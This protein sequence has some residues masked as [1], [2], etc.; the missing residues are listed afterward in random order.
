MHLLNRCGAPCIIYNTSKS[1]LPNGF[2]WWSTETHFR[3]RSVRIRPPKPHYW[4]FSTTKFLSRRS[5]MSAGKCELSSSEVGLPRT[6]FVSTVRGDE[7]R[8]KNTENRP[9]IDFRRDYRKQKKKNSFLILFHSCWLIKF[10]RHFSS[11]SAR[12]LFDGAPFGAVGRVFICMKLAPRLVR[13]ISKSVS[14][15]S[16]FLATNCNQHK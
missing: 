13:V 9:E 10:S 4:S 1:W 14:I 11:K 6:I 2:S 12:T 7:T 15:F 16:E 3:V 5:K 8:E